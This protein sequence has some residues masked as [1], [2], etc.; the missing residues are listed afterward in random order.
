MEHLDRHLLAAARTR[1]TRELHGD[2]ADYAGR[3]GAGQNGGENAG[4]GPIPDDVRREV[5]VPERAGAD[6]P[7]EAVPGWQSRGTSSAAVGG[8]RGASAWD[9]ARTC[10]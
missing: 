5:D 1:G 9:W 10:C 2:D 6:L 8:A 3:L 7:T 4:G